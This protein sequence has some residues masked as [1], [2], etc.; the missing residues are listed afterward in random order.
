[1]R[2]G[3]IVVL[4]ALVGG[5]VATSAQ[6]APHFVV[7]QGQNPG[8]AVDAAGTAYIGWQ[9]NT[10]ADSGDA[11]QLCVLPAGAR[12]CAG[13]A[14]IPFPG[15]GFDN[16][17]V[18]VLL[19]APGVVQVTVGRNVLNVYGYYLATSGDG[20]A[21]FG[22][23][24]RIGGAFAK[25][26]ALL[27]GGL[28]AAE[29]DD[30]RQL[31]GAVLRPEGSDAAVDAPALDERAQFSD[32]TVQGSDV[33]IAGSLAGPTTAAR[34]PAGANSSDPAAWQRLPELNSG[35]DPR[36][37]P[38]PAG[39]VVLLDPLKPGDAAP[40][41]QHWTGT[42]WTPPV[43]VGPDNS[44]DARAITRAGQR[45]LAAWSVTSPGPG[46]RVEFAM[47]LDGGALWSSV[48]TMA[49]PSDARY[50][51]QAGMTPAGNGVVVSG[52]FDDDQ[53]IEVFVV[54]PHRAKVARARFGTTTVQLRADEGDCVEETHLSL[55]VQ[56][57]RNGLLVSPGTVL[58]GAHISVRRARVLH[59][60]RRATLVDLRGAK[61]TAT[62]RLVP[63]RG[64]ARTLRLPVRACGRVA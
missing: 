61:R 46:H 4:A 15:T 33:Y 38:G 11:V 10:H 6:A 13:L 44:N 29:G 8:V 21:T 20:G 31:G 9:V 40:F 1:M 23:P 45:L 39:P 49:T 59:R 37:A 22:A 17:R 64:H 34:L 41:V 26:A 14:T 25:R 36:L 54:D 19:P 58:R 7:G 27:P 56:A 35:S 47:S 55:R 24:L 12:A 60:S 32:V 3:K 16:G 51:L 5:L 50:A 28:I 48:S 18:S 62:V 57:A 53:P 43:T 52:G 2:A 63:R 30:V 42:A